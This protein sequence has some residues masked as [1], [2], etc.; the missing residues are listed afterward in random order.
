MKLEAPKEHKQ[1]IEPNA[2][3]RY[4][5]KVGSTP[6]ARTEDEAL[7]NYALIEYEE[8]VLSPAVAKN[9]EEAL[10]LAEAAIRKAH[11]GTN[12]PSPAEIIIFSTLYNIASKAKVDKYPAL[13]A[14][15]AKVVSTNWAK[16]GIEKVAISTTVKP[17]KKSK[18]A[19]AKEEDATPGRVYVKKLKEGVQMKIPKPGEDMYVS[20]IL[21]TASLAANGFAA[22]PFLDRGIS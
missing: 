3:V 17:T 22:F 20:Q 11:L 13:S 7:K 2:I 5:A 12:P 1:L 6:W 21:R 4:L 16:H 19:P 15:F 10:V 14:W 9:A 18:G 8:S